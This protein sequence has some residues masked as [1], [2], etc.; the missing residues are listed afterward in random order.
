MPF[1]VEQLLGERGK[2]LTV[3]RQGTV[4]QALDRMLEHDYS[5]LPVV[6]QNDYPCGLITTDSIL[7]AVNCLGVSPA[8]LGVLPA[9]RRVPIYRI[10]ADLF[11]VLDGVRDASAVLIVDSKG[12]LIGIVTSYDTTDYFH[13]RAEDLMLVEDVELTLRDYVESGYLDTKGEVDPVRLSEA[14]QAITPSNRGALLGRFRQALRSYLHTSGE[15]NPQLDSVILNQTFEQH[16]YTPAQPTPV[17]RLDLSDYIQLLRNIWDHYQPTFT[18]EWS[19]ME[20]L[21]SAVRETRNA[22]AHFREVTPEQRERL[23]FCTELL[24]Q[25]PPKLSINVAVELPPLEIQ[26]EIQV[27]P[28]DLEPADAELANLYGPILEEEI[29][30]NESR[31][32]PLALYLQRLPLQEDKVRLHFKQIEEIIQGSLP[33][34]ARQYRNW[35][36]NDPVSHPQSQQ[37]LEA[38]WK[39]SGVNIGEQKVVFSRIGERQGDYIH[40]FS[41]IN[42]QLRQQSSLK[43]LPKPI[44]SRHWQVLEIS[45]PG[46]DGSLWLVLSFAR[47]R[48]LRVEFYINSGNRE[49]NKQIFE[50]LLQQ[51]VAIEAAV[52]EPLSWERLDLRQGCRI[53]LYHEGA[54][55]DT[56][57]SLVA[58]QAWAID[59]VLRLYQG[60]IEP[61]T[62][63]RG[64]VIENS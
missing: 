5:Q 15:P 12:C 57:E 16:L 7:R 31:Y 34:S 59:A 14:V 46:Q 53:A 43:I 20:R 39:V 21:L 26:G 13:R 37:W 58:L 54:I 25:F 27:S 30:A 36:A 9:T 38:G 42:D 11:E 52:G 51:Q 32:T 2:P 33:P 22:V 61:M 63:V 41:T 35:W 60:L 18:V 62:A 24:A 64:T 44:S 10:D 1:T 45:Q 3:E 17:D 29:E 19:A 50:Q 28:L 8:Q 47:R 49:K 4:K 23:R 40:F 6:D 48:K 55:T 56:P